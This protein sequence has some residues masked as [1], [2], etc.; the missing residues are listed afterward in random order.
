M[1]QAPQPL[2]QPETRQGSAN[3]YAADL[4]SGA[5]SAE[6][7]RG[8]ATDEQQT[9]PESAHQQTRREPASAPTIQREVLLAYFGQ[10]AYLG[11]VSAEAVSLEAKLLP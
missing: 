4:T 2:R 11:P 5:S 10:S 7:G 8:A 3:R 1:S 6:D 9:R